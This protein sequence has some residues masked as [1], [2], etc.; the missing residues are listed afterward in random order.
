M[1]RF[2]TFPQLMDELYLH[3]NKQRP[4]TN[5]YTFLVAIF[6]SYMRAYGLY[7]E[8]NVSCCNLALLMQDTAVIDEQESNLHRRATPNH[9]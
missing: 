4:W 6:D 1:R 7:S 8:I 3:A 2:L 5:G 9:H